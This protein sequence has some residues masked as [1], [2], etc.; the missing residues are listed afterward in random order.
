MPRFTLRSDGRPEAT[1]LTARRHWL[2]QSAALGVALAAPLALPVQAAAPLLWL[3]SADQSPPY[4][5]ALAAVRESLPG[6]AMRLFG[7]NLPPVT[8]GAP[9]PDLILTLGTAALRQALELASTQPTLAQVPV[10]AGLLPRSSYEPLAR[11]PPPPLTAVWLDP[12]PERPLDLIRLAMPQRRKVAVIWGPSSRIWRGAVAA[13]A[14]ERG[15]ELIEATVPT[16]ELFPALNQV[17]APADVL[18]LM[19]DAAVYPPEQLNH[20]LLTAYRQRVPVLGFAAAQARAGATLAL[21]TTPE[22]AG[23]QLGQRVRRWLDDR[24]Q[25][26]APGP[27][28]QWTLE[29]NEPVAQSLGLGLP[30]AEALTQALRRLDPRS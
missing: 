10:A 18:L 26:P 25:W 20:V 6:V 16:L 23:R 3:I 29:T 15:L 19:P 21:F 27:S 9:T 12:A 1:P 5:Q 17:L 24:R 11:R 14:G 2:Q 28:S 30:S 8:V 13:A 4:A 22:Q 7:P